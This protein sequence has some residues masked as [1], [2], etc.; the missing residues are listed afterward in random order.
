M[1]EAWFNDP[2]KVGATV[3]LMTAVWALAS[4][5]LLTPKTVQQMLDA[6]EARRVADNEMW[7]EREK[8]LLAELDEFKH[9]ALRTLSIT[10][11]AIGVAEKK[12]NT[13]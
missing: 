9:M 8:R 13:G 3:L 4:N 1:I 5:R 10:D 6:A 7:R 12:A 11:R 2:S